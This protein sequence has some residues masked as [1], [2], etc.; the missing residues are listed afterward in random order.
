MRNTVSKTE[1]YVR[2]CTLNQ[3]TKFTIAF[4]AK[5]LTQLGA[6]EVIFILK[7]VHPDMEIIPHLFSLKN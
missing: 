5:I 4:T 3:D 7:S 1:R 6:F 2:Q